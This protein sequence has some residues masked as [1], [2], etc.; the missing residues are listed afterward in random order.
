MNHCESHKDDETYDS[1]DAMACPE[2]QRIIATKYCPGCNRYYIDW[3]NTAFDDY[4]AGPAATSLGDFVCMRCLPGVER[5]IE[6]IEQDD[7]WFDLSGYDCVE[8]FN[9]P[10]ASE[11]F[12][13]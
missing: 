9:T 11:D 8:N 1:P 5:E 2:C 4:M 7:D 12:E 3:S 13:D 10:N 6:R